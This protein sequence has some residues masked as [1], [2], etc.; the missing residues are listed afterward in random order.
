[1]FK[2]GR[3]E[4]ERESNFA[5]MAAARTRTH[6]TGP[7][8]PAEHHATMVHKLHL[9]S[10]SVNEPNTNARTS[11]Q[12]VSVRSSDRVSQRTLPHP[13]TNKPEKPSPGYYHSMD[14]YSMLGCSVAAWAQGNSMAM[15][16]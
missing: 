2:N 6:D 13:L 16:R 12:L 5:E 8:P 1:M 7:T 10:S 4:R 9:R 14:Q 15:E 3:K 11:M